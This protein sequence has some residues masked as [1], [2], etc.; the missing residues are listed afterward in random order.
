MCGVYVCKYMHVVYLNFSFGHCPMSVCVSVCIED[1][2]KVYKIIKG[3]VRKGEGRGKTILFFWL[4]LV[5]E[6]RYQTTLHETQTRQDS[7]LEIKRHLGVQLV[8]HVISSICDIDPQ[9]SAYI[10]VLTYVALVFCPIQHI[11]YHS[12]REDHRRSCRC[13]PTWWLFSVF[14][15]NL[16]GNDVT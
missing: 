12:F 1:G 13:T 5:L 15:R 6:P 7:I 9:V 11:L 8:Q 10:A 2:V 4:Q 14:L 3:E 16:E